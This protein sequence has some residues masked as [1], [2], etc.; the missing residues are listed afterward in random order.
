MPNQLSSL[1]RDEVENALAAHYLRSDGPCGAG[2]L[3]YIDATRSE[4]ALA[5]K[6]N[7]ASVIKKLAAACDGASTVSDVLARGWN[8]KWPETESPGYFRFLVLTCAVVAAADDNPD[9]RDFGRNLGR[10]L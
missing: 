9:T 5:L 3:R 4:L 2:P 10:A 7:E 8:R 1:L 6:T